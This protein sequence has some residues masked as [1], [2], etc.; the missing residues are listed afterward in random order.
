MFRHGYGV[1]HDET[2]PID[3]DAFDSCSAFILRVPGENSR[4]I[5]CADCGGTC[6]IK[7]WHQQVK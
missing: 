5:G 6:G 1:M 7:F 3:R 2:Y 4:A